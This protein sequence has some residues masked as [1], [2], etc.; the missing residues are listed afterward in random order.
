VAKKAK[1]EEHEN[2]ERWLISYADFIT[3]LFA[4]FVVMYSLSSINEGKFRVLAQSVAASF[5]GTPRSSTPIQVGSPTMPGMDGT[6]EATSPRSK[7]SLA[8]EPIATPGLP[9][10]V[11]TRSTDVTNDGEQTDEEDPETD[12]QATGGGAVAAAGGPMS[13]QGGALQEIAHTIEQEMF[14]LIKEGLVKI[15]RFQFWLE[16]EINT[17]VLFPS[18]SDRLEIEAIPV[19]K[20]IA[21]V[22]SGYA[23]PLRVE[24]FTDD[25]P[26]NT[27]VFPSNWELSTARATSVVHLL[28]EEGIAAG[29]MAAVGHGEFKPVMPNDTAEGRRENRRVVL[30]VLSNEGLSPL[31]DTLM[32]PA[33]EDAQRE[34][35]APVSGAVKVLALAGEETQQDAPAPVQ[36]Q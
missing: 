23:N 32:G 24:G 1:H 20:K 30:V 12:A 15:R 16:I 27:P 33:A 22:L 34:E 4:F 11:M 14:P 18:G 9:I 36:E 8:V 29:R 26:I 13:K 7:P 21:A 19:L 17:A 10:R 35:A 31:R 25:V 2:H 6:P 3:L 28:Q 5:H